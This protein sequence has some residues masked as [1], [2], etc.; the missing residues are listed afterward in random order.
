MSEVKLLTEAEWRTTLRQWVN[1]AATE[2]VIRELRERGLI[3]PEPVDPLLVE[4]LELAAQS[5]E[6]QGDDVTAREIRE[7][8]YNHEVDD[9]TTLPGLA[10]SALRRGMELGRSDRS[11]ALAHPVLTREMVREAV[12][13][14]VGY[15]LIWEDAQAVADALNAA[16][17]EARNS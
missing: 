5:F 4:A 13:Q 12:F 15:P 7:G 17:T 11:E 9:L 10:L 6:L 14:R 1:I 2:S 8:V 16:L 3:A